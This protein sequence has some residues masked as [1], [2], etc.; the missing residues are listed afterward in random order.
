MKKR[1]L[2]TLLL[3]VASP[4]FAASET[5]LLDSSGERIG[6]L[7]G[8]SIYLWSGKPVAYL[9]SGNNGDDVYGINGKHLGWFMRGRIWNH[10]GHMSCT[11]KDADPSRLNPLKGLKGAIPAKAAREAAPTKPIFAYIF[12]DGTCRALLSGGS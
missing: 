3:L 12:D 5:P 8:G 11:T 4:S 1:V 6:Y 9:A 7:D 10:G 2:P